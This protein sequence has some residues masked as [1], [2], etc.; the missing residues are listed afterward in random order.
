MQFGL[1]YSNEYNRQRNKTTDTLTALSFAFNIWQV[2]IKSNP[3]K[4]NKW[5]AS[6]F[7]RNDLLP[8][9]T[10]LQQANKS[11]NFNFFT[12]ILKNENRQL[13]LN[14]TYRKLHIINAAISQQKAD[15]SLLGRTEY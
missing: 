15:E 11:D 12:E 5:G 6:Y 8:V 9:K 13:R 1:N 2:Y 7:T 10:I 3:Q 4:A 14:I